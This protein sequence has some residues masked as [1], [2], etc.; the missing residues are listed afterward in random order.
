MLMIQTCPCYHYYFQ[1]PPSVLERLQISLAFDIDA[2]QALVDHSIQNINV[3]AILSFGLS[4]IKFS[5][6]IAGFW[7]LMLLHPCSA[8]CSAQHQRKAMQS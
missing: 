5:S 6:H 4:N 1:K 3:R 7:L 8:L 2:A